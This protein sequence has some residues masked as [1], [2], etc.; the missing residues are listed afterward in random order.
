MLL[1]YR[2][3]AFFISQT[4][5]PIF[6]VDTGAAVSILPKSSCTGYKPYQ[7]DRPLHAVNHSSIPTYGEKSALLD[8]GL[9]R[10][11]R[12]VFVVAAVSFPILRADFLHHFNLSVDLRQ[13]RLIDNTTNCATV[14][15]AVSASA[16]SPSFLPLVAASTSDSY[17]SLLKEFHDITQP[18]Y[19]EHPITHNVTHSTSLPQVHHLFL[20]LVVWHRT[21]TRMRNKNSNTCCL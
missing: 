14:A 21:V 3:L 6:L 8:V 9:R 1:A 17:T 5:P 20:V 11:F 10:A 19:H 15:S 13:Q 12:W 18:H 4:N 2:P 7:S 16:L